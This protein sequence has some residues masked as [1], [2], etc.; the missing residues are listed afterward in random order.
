MC[1]N[2]RRVNSQAVT[3]GS[4]LTSKAVVLKV[5]PP[6]QQRQ[7]GEPQRRTEVLNLGYPFESPGVFK[8]L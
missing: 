8:K 6:E 1:T 7:T 4:L 2:Q 5:C 3:E